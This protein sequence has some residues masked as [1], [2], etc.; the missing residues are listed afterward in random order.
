MLSAFFGIKYGNRVQS[1][2][3]KIGRILEMYK[4]VSVMDVHVDG[5]ELVANDNKLTLD[6][7][8]DSISPHIDV[9]NKVW[10]KSPKFCTVRFASKSHCFFSWML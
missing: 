8:M 4:Y 7:I 6:F 1:Q 9:M 2:S 5:R 3:S 10:K